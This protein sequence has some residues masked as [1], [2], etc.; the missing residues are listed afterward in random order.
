MRGWKGCRRKSVGVKNNSGR[1]FSESDPYKKITNQNHHPTVKPIKLMQYLVRLI[2]PPGGTVI[3]PFM[4]SG[5][6]GIAAYREGCEFIGIELEQE[7][8]DIAQRR[9]SHAR[10]NIQTL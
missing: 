5:T 1:G 9:I 10:S 7:Y 6:T 4:G 2:T 8:Y 3:D